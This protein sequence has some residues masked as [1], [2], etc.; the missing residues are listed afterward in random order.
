ML[1]IDNSA[2]P[3]AIKQASPHGL[4][5]FVSIFK[6]NMPTESYFL[7]QASLF[8]GIF[9]LA[10]CA[11]LAFF[12]LKLSQKLTRLREK[13]YLHQIIASVA[14]SPN[15]VI[16]TNPQ[17]IIQY[18]NPYFTLLT[19]YTP[20]DSIGH[21]TNLLQSG[22]TPPK[23]YEE[24]W[25]TIQ[26]GQ[27]WQGDLLNQHKSGKQYW[28]ETFILPL[29]QNGRIAHFIATCADVTT[30]K[31]LDEIINHR[32][33]ELSL[34]NTI[35][36]A[37]ASQLDADSLVNLAG[38]QL[39]D[40]FNVKSVFVALYDSEKQV[41]NTP[42]WSID[43]EKMD[44]PPM[45][46]GQGLTS[47]VIQRRVPLLIDEDFETIAPPLGAKLIFAQAKGLP[48]TWLGVPLLIG[49]EVLGVISLQDYEHEHA[50]SAED[51]RLL[52]TIAANMGIALQNA[53]LFNEAQQEIAER[54]RAEDELRRHAEET[55]LFY[56]IS[57]ELSADLNLNQVLRNLLEK[58]RQLLPLDSFYIALYD[59]ASQTIHHPL[60][61]DQGKFKNVPARDLHTTPG[62]IG[63]IIFSRKTLYLPDTLVPEIAKKYQIIHAGGTPSRSFVG[64]PMLSHGQIIGAISMKSYQPH[65]YTPNHI[66]ML[67][68]IASQAAIAIQ[69]SRL[70]EAAC[71]EAQERRR[72]QENLQQTNL[73]LQTHIEHIEAIKDELREQSIRDALTGLY[74]RRYLNEVF[75]SKLE[76]AHRKSTPFSV[77]MLDIDLFK[78]FN[79]TYG[80]AQGDK[81][82]AIL[83][84]LLRK[85]TRASD[86][87]CRYGGEEFLILLPDTPLEIAYRRAEEVRQRFESTQI[88]V[89]HQPVSATISLGIA[90]YPKHAQTPE[91]L[92]VQADQAMYAAKAAGR[93]R[94]I[95]W[96]Q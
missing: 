86:I 89:N 59:D 4:A 64:V 37:A 95:V 71:T 42:Y 76:Y 24:L 84:N 1:E 72:D 30:H 25:Q 79:D 60:F 56:E 15:A 87:A 3:N 96:E 91:G 19:G 29:F 47:I 26:I 36:L 13:A 62:I 53:R 44:A 23:I 77:I 78:Q 45:P 43:R 12:T 8:W 54:K 80:H 48:K 28:Q 32:L 69:N 34:V 9:I 35:S 2:R 73:A 40:A 14:N 16:I 33:D 57:Q 41:I 66:H 38:R 22:K 17:G 46:Y 90:G 88:Q 55:A 18:V 94:V 11:G 51:V 92:I 70:Y 31:S 74:N 10:I 49:A 85:Q 20:E 61:F 52:T 27:L 6:N 63:E 82:L 7:L 5:C 58:C 81:L 39:E 83:G 93:N 67:E 65:C 75:K 21:K 50:F 68:A